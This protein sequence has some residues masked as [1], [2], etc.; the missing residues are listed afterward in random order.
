MKHGALLLMGLLALS[1]AAHAQYKVVEPGGRIIYTDR[2]PNDGS[3]VT[4]LRAQGGTESELAKLPLALREPVSRYP[5]TLYTSNDVC[6]PCDNARA[7]LRQ[8]GIPYAEKQAQSNEGKRQLEAL[9]GALEVP[10]LTIGGQVLRG[11]SP[12]SWQGY[13]DAAG[14]P[15]SSVLPSSYQQAPA[16]P[17][18][19]A[20]ANKQ[21]APQPAFTPELP[22]DVPAQNP[23]RF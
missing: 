20:Q 11:F 4:P 22:M 8:R 9:I 7:L 21:A 12:D 2:P 17:L 19:G 18:S 6:L 3:K 23:V 10:A 5:V 1:H 15:R 14:Y 16:T 13:L